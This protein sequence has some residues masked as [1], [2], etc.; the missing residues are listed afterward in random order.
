VI[1]Q[2]PLGGGLV[3]Q[4]DAEDVGIDACT[5]LINLEFDKPGVL[6]KR[7]GLGAPTT[8]STYEINEIAKWIDADDLAQWILCTADGKILK[9]TSLLSL[10]QIAD[11]DTQRLRISNYGSMLR[12]SSEHSADPVLLQ[13]IDRDFFSAGIDGGSA[14]VLDT[15]KARVDA[16][17]VTSTLIN[18]DSKMGET[19]IRDFDAG[20]ADTYQYNLG[21]I[22]TLVDTIY[23]YRYSLIFDGNQESELSSVFIDSGISAGTNVVMKIQMSINAGATLSSWNKRIT[24]INIYRST[25][26]EAN[27]RKILVVNTKSANSD[28]TYVNPVSKAGKLYI[29]GAT[30]AE[31]CFAGAYAMV[32]GKPYAILSNTGKLINLSATPV[33]NGYA[34]FNL[35]NQLGSQYEYQYG[36][37]DELKFKDTTPIR[38]D[39][40]GY[41]IAT[42]SAKFDIGTSAYGWTTT[43]NQ[44]YT[45]GTDGSMKSANM[46]SNV[47]KFV[48]TS[49]VNFS[50]KNLTLSNDTT[51]V[52]SGWIGNTT[53]GASGGVR[54]SVEDAEISGTSP[55]G[56]SMIK[57][58]GGVD[59]KFWSY[60]QL[61]FTTG[62]I[63]G[64]PFIKVQ[65]FSSGDICYLD[66]V[67]IFQ[68][69]ASF[70]TTDGLQGFTGDNMIYCSD[71]NLAPNSKVGFP[72]RLNTTR[73]NTAD[74]VQPETG[75]ITQS[76]DKAIQTAR[77]NWSMVN[78]IAGWDHGNDS[79]DVP[80]NAKVAGS[81]YHLMI[82]DGYEWSQNGDTQY[83]T[84]WDYGL[85]DGALHPN[86]ET[87]L[88]TKFKYSV[89][90]EGRQY[91]G[92]VKIE[93]TDGIETH[94][95]WVMFSDLNQPDV[96]PITNYISIPDLQGGEIKGL[97]R[98]LGDLVVLQS[99]GIYRISIPSAD[100]SSWSL[101]ESEPNI[102]CIASD[103]IVEHDSGVFF[104]GKDHMYYLS[105]NFEAIPITTSIKDVYQ[106]TAYLENTRAM[107]DVKKNRLLCKFGNSNNTIYVL[108]LTKKAQ[109]VEH[110]SKIDNSGSKNADLF[111]IDENLT[112]YAVESGSTSYLVEF[113]SDQPS[114]NVGFT[115]KTGWISIG[116]LDRSGVVRRFNIR[117]L[118][119][120]DITV[121]FYIDG[122]TSTVVKT[123][124]IPADNSGADWYKSKPNV[125]CR[126]FMIELTQPA[127][128]EDVEIRRMEVEFE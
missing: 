59:F 27:F 1:K 6:Y 7:G 53:T 66:E 69:H 97:A 78:G 70:L 9:G 75:W 62:T 57:S 92:N 83:L 14:Y 32:S 102:G 41:Y 15:A 61:E 124:T 80:L 43:S 40:Y 96:I 13:K 87:S 37:V 107:V 121:K 81:S 36:A 95:D 64:T 17:N 49:A 119:L 126:Y 63:T 73:S 71:L 67:C 98:L 47:H 103:S 11:L 108:D 127:D 35:S 91:V 54:I 19:Q 112:V 30:Y 99:K 65:L 56:F 72:Y 128:G 28:L 31:N 94:K 29:K 60:F 120:S 123:I 77:S 111:A 109:G 84:F 3:T 100:P 86:G 16:I 12:F 52:L 118:S 104:A 44:T 82:G 21:S 93:S 106:M 39:H 76:T 23:Y 79:V 45:Y 48:A 85:T 116:D 22:E 125:R 4:A 10:T 24:H 46:Q 115:R 25:N 117:H 26:P 74:Y 110:W 55:K 89:N 88:N 42:G 34:T 20:T 113:D 68:K 2:I 114:E 90:L 33:G 5:E 58:Y 38:G 105:A 122:D 18:I 51:Y 8:I 50:K 101:S